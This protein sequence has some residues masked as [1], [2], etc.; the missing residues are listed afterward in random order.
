[1][2]IPVEASS[3]NAFADLGLPD[4]AELETKTRLAVKINGLIA[5]QRLN[6]V[7]AAARLE[8]SCSSFDL[9]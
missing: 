2:A 6:E 9:I 1:M 4:A 3:G 7:E 5:A 8:I